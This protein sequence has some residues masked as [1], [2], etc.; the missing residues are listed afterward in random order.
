[1]NDRPDIASAV[2]ADGV[3]VG[4]EELPAEVAR[5][6]VGP[7]RLV[8]VSTLNQMPSEVYLLGLHAEVNIG[9]VLPAALIL[10]MA[11]YFL[12]IPQHHDS[13][14]PIVSTTSSA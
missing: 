14:E 11:A 13:A 4:Q 7:E 12:R 9:G 2:D 8:G 1:M 5:K 10:G 3:H 6:L